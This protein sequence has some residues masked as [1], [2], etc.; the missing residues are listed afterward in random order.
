MMKTDEAQISTILHALQERAKEL[1]CLYRVDEFLNIG[2]IS[3]WR[4]LPWDHR[5]SA[6]GLA[7]PARLPGA[8]HF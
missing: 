3:R 5:C 8:N 1:N 2:P 7:I 4:N 6:A